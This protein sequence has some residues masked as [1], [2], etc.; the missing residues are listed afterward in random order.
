[1]TDERWP[2]PARNEAA[3]RLILKWLRPLSDETRDLA[4]DD[5]HRAIRFAVQSVTRE[6]RDRLGL[7]EGFAVDR[8]YLARLL[9]AADE[10]VTPLQERQSATP[11]LADAQ[12]KEGE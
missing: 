6:I 7:N 3:E 11:R 2:A 1:M 5:V 9:D 8:D 10:R 4:R 12:G